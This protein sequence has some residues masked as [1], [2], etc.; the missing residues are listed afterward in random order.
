MW[1]SLTIYAFGHWLLCSH[2]SDFRQQSQDDH[3]YVVGC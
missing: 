1:L 3:N 2:G